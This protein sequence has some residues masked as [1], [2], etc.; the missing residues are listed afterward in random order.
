MKGECR[1]MSKVKPPWNYFPIHETKVGKCKASIEVGFD[2]GESM[3]FGVGYWD[4]NGVLTGWSFTGEVFREAI[5]EYLDKI[6]LA[7]YINDHPIDKS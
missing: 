5:L 7:Q 3:T 2:Q 4:E 1:K 6:S